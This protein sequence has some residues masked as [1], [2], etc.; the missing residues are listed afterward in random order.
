MAEDKGKEEEEEKLDFTPEGEGNISLGDARILA[1]RTAAESPGDY[2][3]DFREVAMV[4]EVVESGEDGDHYNITLSFRPQGYFDGWRGEEQFIIGRDGT[5]AIRQ[6]LSFPVRKGGGFPLLPVAIG[7]VVVGVIAAV[8]A[9]FAL[10]STGD[11]G[12]PVALVTPP[13]TKTPVTPSATT[14]PL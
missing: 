6:V 7:L 8:G 5:I 14:P 4:F 11:D 3:R 10:G 9:V 1:V 12:A 2:G 13:E